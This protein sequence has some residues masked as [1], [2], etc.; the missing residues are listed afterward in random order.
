MLKR[1]TLVLFVLLPTLTGTVHAFTFSPKSNVRVSVSSCRHQV[2]NPLHP[3]RLCTLGKPGSRQQEL[4]KLASS[5]SSPDDN[6]NNSLSSSPNWTVVAFLGTISFLY[7]Y[8]MVLAAAAVAND[9][10]AVPDF[11]P[12]VPG[13]PPSDQD[14]QPVMEDAFH[15]F[16]LSELLQN[17]D[18]PAV[19]PLRLAAF[20]I[21]EAWIFAYLIPLWNDPKRL[22]RPVLLGLWMLL[23][24]NLTNAFLAPYLMATE[25][26]SSNDNDAESAKDTAEV[27]PG[28]NPIV[29]TIFGAIATAVITYA[30]GQSIFVADAAAW[31]EFQTLVV[32]D[33]T[34][35]AFCV[36]LPLFAV[37]QPLI[38]SRVN[39]KELTA[40]DY[41]PIV[42]LLNWMFF[43]T[44]KD[45]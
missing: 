22:P 30:I 16:Y 9:W 28:K 4:F 1:I 31:K 26:L 17:S 38:L 36:D 37:F 40:I 19:N 15:F 25:I 2:S 29:A 32:S 5:S 8:W 6:N 39:K 12:L 34:Y 42:G 44:T 24:I 3:T 14:L 7:W 10:P 43:A 21:D 35:L 45:D 41:V 27:I 20:N 13:W 33:R 23:G 18:A 11:I